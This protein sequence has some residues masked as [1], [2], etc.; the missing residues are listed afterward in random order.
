[1]IKTV[2]FAI[3]GLAL[4]QVCAAEDWKVRANTKPPRAP[5]Q[6]HVT[7]DLPAPDPEFPT[8]LDKKTTAKAGCEAAKARKVDPTEMAEGKCPAYTD[9]AVALC[10][11]EGVAL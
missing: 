5:T 6:C 7:N 11:K 10:K 8:V 4:T 3:L 2:L 9:D 1:M